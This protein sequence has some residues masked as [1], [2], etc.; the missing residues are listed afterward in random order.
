M[1]NK[2][3]LFL[4]ALFFLSGCTL[5]NFLSK[6]QKVTPATQKILVTPSPEE[7]YSTWTDDAGFVFQYGDSMT[8]KQDKEDDTSYT[9]LSLTKVGELGEIKIL[10][11][12][13]KLKDINQWNKSAD[14]IIIGGKNALSVVADDKTTIG[15]IDEGTLFTIEMT[16]SSPTL[17]NTF[18][19]IKNTFEFVY[20]TSSAKAT[21]NS[22]LDDAIEEESVEE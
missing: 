15:V 7:I 10:A 11:K 16:G 13:T 9:N 14:D 22:A 12:D 18:E 21:D 17:N 6:N 5:P 1:R 4:I 3:L 2:V 20:P 19:K 8:I